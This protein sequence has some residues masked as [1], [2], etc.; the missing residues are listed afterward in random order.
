MTSA[1]LRAKRDKVLAH[2]DVVR[3]SKGDRSVEYSEASESLA[4][5]DQEIARAEASEAGTARIRQVRLSS[6]KGF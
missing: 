4:V 3:V 6:D 1:E 5:L 2:C